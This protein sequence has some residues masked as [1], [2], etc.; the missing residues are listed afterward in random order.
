MG[1]ADTGGSSG[2][3]AVRMLGLCVRNRQWM[4][5]CWL[6][7]LRVC[8][9]GWQHVPPDVPG[10]L[11]RCFGLTARKAGRTGC[12]VSV[13]WSD[14]TYREDVPVVL[15]LWVGLTARTGEMY[16]VFCVGVLGWQHVE[17]RR[18]GCFMSVGWA[19]SVYRGELPGVLCLSVGLTTRTGETYRG[20]CVWV[21]NWQHIQDRRTG[22]LCLCVG[23]TAH[24]S[25]T[26]KLIYVCVLGWQHVQGRRT[27]YFCRVL[28]G[29]HVQGR[30][31]GCFVS[32]VGLRARTG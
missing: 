32:S 17:C 16:R 8:V 24:T 23:L 30:R 6:L 29:E 10:V 1:C 14:S 18:T 11:C 4:N 3:T 26:K 7:V 13:F 27:H 21:M 31:T 2:T 22:C 20:F 25:Y 9:L 28:G 19:D 12:F 5:I 15:C